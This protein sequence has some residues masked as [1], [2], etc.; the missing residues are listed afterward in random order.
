M[1]YVNNTQYQISQHH[2]GE[3][4]TD[5]TELKKLCL[6]DSACSNSYK[7]LEN[8]SVNAIAQHKI[9]SECRKAALALQLNPLLH[10]K[11]H[12]GMKREQHCLK[13]YWAIHPFMTQG[14]FDLES[15]PYEDEVI[16]QTWT[17]NH[18][19]L[20]APAFDSDLAGDGANLCVHV[21]DICNADKKCSKHRTNY[22]SNCQGVGAGES[23]KRRKCQ[24]YL[25]H[26]FRKVPEDFIKKILFCPCQ[27]S[28]CAERRRQTIFPDCSFQ[29]KSKPNCLQ[30]VDTCHRHH[31]CRSRLADFRTHCQLLGSSQTISSCEQDGRC[32]QSYTRMIGTAMTPNYTG[33]T[34]MEVSLWCSCESS[35]N[36]HDECEKIFNMFTNN[37]CLKNA[38]ESQMRVNKMLL[39]VRTSSHT[40]QWDVPGASISSVPDKVDVWWKTNPNLQLQ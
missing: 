39:T 4:L 21:A 5:C 17:G 29:V 1:L 10:C 12:R 24:R 18:T 31:G 40:I 20:A 22:V 3:V 19:Q 23:C 34:S 28:S 27:D 6:A 36:E 14:Y 32:L 8:C 9:E 38:I 13:I 35:G 26:F 11:C 15:S 33:N 37:I 7:T 16:E 25:R 30:L 2:S